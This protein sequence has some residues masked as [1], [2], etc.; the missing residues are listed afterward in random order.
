MAPSTTAA[1]KGGVAANDHTID[2]MSDSRPK[3]PT[4]ELLIVCYA[5]PSPI[6]IKILKIQFPV[7]HLL[8]FPKSS[9]GPSPDSPIPKL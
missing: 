6:K 5:L 2:A 4:K 7:R 1:T 8:E 3:E 9:G